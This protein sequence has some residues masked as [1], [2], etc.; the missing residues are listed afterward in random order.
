[1]RFSGTVGFATSTETSP[2][3]WTDTIDERLY[4]GDV[5][6]NSRRLEP[7]SQVPPVTNANISLG[8]SFSIVADAMAFENYQHMRYVHWNGGYW[9]I[10][11]VSVARPRL[12]LTIGGQWNGIKA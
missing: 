6:Q 5:N 4:F 1:V 10:T 2:G 3:V 9:T 11:D 8:N 7:P 12:I